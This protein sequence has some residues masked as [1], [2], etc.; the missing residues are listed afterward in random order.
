MLGV[1][2]GL[3]ATGAGEHLAGELK[4][5]RCPPRNLS[6]SR[7]AW[8]RKRGEI[9]FLLGKPELVAKGH[10][11]DI[12]M[13]MMIHVGSHDQMDKR[14]YIAD[15]S[16]GAV[17]KQIRFLGLARMLRCAAARH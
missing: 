5:S 9:E 8:R 16:N 2:V 4:F 15:S 17:V 14:S 10:F 11:D 7:S 13:A 12:D 3:Q 6:M 1:A